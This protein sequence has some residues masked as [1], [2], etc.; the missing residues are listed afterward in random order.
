MRTSPHRLSADE[1]V[2]LGNKARHGVGGS[3]RGSRKLW[4]F[5]DR[6]RE[7]TSGKGG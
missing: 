7:E 5:E 3:E 1:E 4:E 2:L 6:A